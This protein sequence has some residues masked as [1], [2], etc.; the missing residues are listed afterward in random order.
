[1]TRR[2]DG[3]RLLDRISLSIEP[4]RLLL[5]CGPNGAGK[6]TLLKVIAGLLPPTAGQVLY[7]GRT[8]AEAG[9]ELRRRLGVLLHESALY[10]ELT[11]MENLLFVG[12]LF[13]VPN[14]AREAEA[15]I[16]RLGLRLVA[17][18]PAGHMSRGMK[19]RLSLGRAL[20]HQPSA[21]LL[22]EAYAGLDV[23]WADELTDL[24]TERRSAGTA[25]LLVAHEWRTAWGVADDLAVIVRGRLALSREVSGYHVDDFETDYRHLVIPAATGP[26]AR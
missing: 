5:L 6:S 15:M 14:A 18:E 22:D 7:G 2:I 25:I 20:M 12:R 26:T 24:L 1:M 17:K 10:D 9:P 13:G 4:G 3:R 8:G 21:L 23:R 11:V 19:Q 16:E